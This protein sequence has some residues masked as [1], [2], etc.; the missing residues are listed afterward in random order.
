MRDP[1]L[2]VGWL[3]SLPSG[4]TKTC[5]VLNCLF[6]FTHSYQSSE[7]HAFKVHV[8]PDTDDR[9]FKEEYHRLQ[10]EKDDLQKTNRISEVAFSLF[11]VVNAT[12]LVEDRPAENSASS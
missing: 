11:R 9:R 8:V 1:R 2:P 4:Q 3:R 12:S 10:V 6:H 7:T 5:V